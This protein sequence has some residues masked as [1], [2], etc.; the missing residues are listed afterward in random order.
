MKIFKLL[1]FI[2]IATFIASC[3]RDN[4][5][6]GT[7]KNLE[8]AEFDTYKSFTFAPHVKDLSNNTFF[9]DSEL[10]KLAVK[11]EVKAEMEA[12]GYV[13]QEND[14]DLL[15]TFRV[16]EDDVEITGFEG[17]TDVG[18]WGETRV[19]EPEDAR[20][21]DLE[22]GSILVQMVDVDKSALVWQGYASGI[23]ED[24]SIL[25]KDE[26]RIDQ[27]VERIFHEYDYKAAGYATR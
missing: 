15:L 5:L 21:Y 1:S 22:E 12:L 9:W 16:F 23:V 4:I 2:I 6:V 20:T 3:A 8:E 26:T 24:A 27:A 25:D 18:Y 14:A 19:R 7:D 13:Y 10:M 11:N 17:V